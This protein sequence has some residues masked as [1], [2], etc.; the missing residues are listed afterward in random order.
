MVTRESDKPLIVLADSQFLVIHSLVNLLESEKRYTVCGIAENRLHLINLLTSCLP[1]LL[2]TDY[3]LFD[4]DGINDLI[5]ILHNYNQLSVLIL[6]NQISSNEVNTFARLGIKNIAL[7]T[8]E[9]EH[10][11]ISIEMAVRKKKHFSD[12]ILDMILEQNDSNSTP[13]ESSGLTDSEREIVKM[14][15]DGFTTKEIAGKKHISTHTVMTHRKNIFRK[16]GV[17]SI[18]ELTKFA[19]KNG[20]TDFLDYSI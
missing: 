18:S 6:V 11:L 4:Y 2:I 1:D 15:A 16:L 20:L 19:I 14:I 17:N 10:L 5:S 8:D 12:Q 7:K 3:N 13:A 9:K